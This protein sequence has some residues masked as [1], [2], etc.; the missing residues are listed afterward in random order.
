MRN[1]PL[2]RV[3]TQRFP[4]RS[5]VKAKTLNLL[6]SNPGATKNLKHHFPVAQDPF[7]VPVG[8]SRPR[9]SHSNRVRVHS[10]HRRCYFSAL[11]LGKQLETPPCQC[12]T[13]LCP[14]SHKPPFPS[15]NNAWPPVGSGIPSDSPK[16]FASRS[17]TWQSACFQIETCLQRP[18]RAI[19]VYADV[20]GPELPFQREVRNDRPAFH[21]KDFMLPYCPESTRVVAIERSRH[22][23]WSCRQPAASIEQ[24][25]PVKPVHAFGD[26]C[27]PKEAIRGLRN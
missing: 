22:D 27:E 4:S 3:P 26:G 23:R 11:R 10:R 19:R 9:G 18:Q 2:P 1:S 6:P 5:K 15:A 13:A 17:V 14:P 16:H 12:T 8:V 20:A 24:T 21:V 25:D 7:R